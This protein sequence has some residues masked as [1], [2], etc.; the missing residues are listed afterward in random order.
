MKFYMSLNDDLTRRRFS[1][2]IAVS[3]DIASV[4]GTKF[5]T[6]KVVTI[7]NSVDTSLIRPSKSAEEIRR[8]INIGD[9]QPVV[10]SVGRL[11]P[12]KAYGLFLEAARLIL[13]KRPDVLFVIVGDGPL[14]QELERTAHGLGISTS[15]IFTGFR[16]DVLDVVNAFDIF[17][18]SSAHEGIPMAV[19]EA[20]ALGKPVVSTAV[21]GMVE[22]IEN[23]ASGLLVD[24]GSQEAM[25]D[26]CLTLLENRELRSRIERGAEKRIQQEF[27]IDEQ[28]SR[29]LRLYEEVVSTS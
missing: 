29:V 16:E 10:G 3:N 28:R 8:E 19:L 11:V 27:S 2:I 23:N 25:A 21:G 7:H 14:R 26:R 15:V 9:D 12:V 24:A 13:S 4:M 20:M 17:L 1:K 18:L 22:I 6:E 5:G